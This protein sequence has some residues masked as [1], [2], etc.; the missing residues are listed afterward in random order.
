MNPLD[1]FLGLVMIFFILLGIYRG[2][3]RELLSLLGFILSLYLAIRFYNPLA[4]WAVQWFPSLPTLVSISS[5]LSIFIAALSVTAISGVIFKRL[6]IIADLRAT[7][8]FLGGVF[9]LIKA[10]LINAL[11]V[12]FIVAFTPHGERLV[13]RSTL[14]MTTQQVTT[15]ILKF[16]P[17]ELKHK[18]LNRW[19]GIREKEGRHD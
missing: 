9:G 10:F 2:L 16:A 14:A 6:V 19:Y 1:V 4:H 18:F 3:F 17:P 5:F 15:A 13:K 8:R 11:I 7:D 12:V